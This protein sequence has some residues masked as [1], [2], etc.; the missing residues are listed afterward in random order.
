MNEGT[1]YTDKIYLTTP[2]YSNQNLPVTDTRFIDMP[3]NA[4]GIPPTITGDPVNFYD[5]V[6]GIESEF[7]FSLGSGTI[8]KNTASD[9]GCVGMYDC[10]VRQLARPE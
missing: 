5:A 9:F 10:G 2:S 1:D 3:Y 7:L 4:D 8:T 6:E